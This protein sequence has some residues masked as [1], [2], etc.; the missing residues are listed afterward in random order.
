MKLKH[1]EP[2]DYVS[3]RAGSWDEARP[4]IIGELGCGD[5]AVHDAMIRIYDAIKQR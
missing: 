3:L 5:V 2:V 1:L 4:H